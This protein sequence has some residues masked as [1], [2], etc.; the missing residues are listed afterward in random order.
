MDFYL[1]SALSHAAGAPVPVAA[2]PV[3]VI[4]FTAAVVLAAALVVVTPPS[5][6]KRDVAF[7]L[8]HRPLT[9]SFALTVNNARP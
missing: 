8:G 5:C 4:L 1:F 3:T 9:A 2:V 7:F 6:R